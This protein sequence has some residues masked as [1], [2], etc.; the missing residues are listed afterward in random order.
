MNV[1]FHPSWRKEARELK[2]FL[3]KNKITL[4]V[5]YV[6]GGDGSL[7]A[8]LSTTQPNLLISPLTCKGYYS[9]ARINNYKK[10]LLLYAKNPEKHHKEF[11]TIKVSINVKELR[12]TALNEVL[13][14]EGLQHVFK[15]LVN[16][17]KELNSGI[18]VYTHHG[19]SG[20]AKN[21]GAKQFKGVG[22]TAVAPLRGLLKRTGSIL[23]DK[24]SIKILARHEP[25]LFFD[26]KDIKPYDKACT[27]R[28]RVYM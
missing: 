27:D 17:K 14:T 9:F 7:F 8:Y 16:G 25:T 18:M 21:L 22:I 5:N 13:V 26:C 1:S 15:S 2:R 23:K 28:G 20:Y 3:K 12:D 24:I 10:R 4:N 11:S 19:W 6:I